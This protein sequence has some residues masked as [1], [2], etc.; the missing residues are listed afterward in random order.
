MK[1]NVESQEAI[2]VPD[3]PL[4]PD[5]N[6]QHQFQRKRTIYRVYQVIWYI[7]GVI[8]VLLVFRIVLKLLGANPLSGFANFIYSLSA[9]FAVPF[10]GVLPASAVG[11][12]VIEWS[13]FLA[14][15]VYLVLA[16][17]LVKL[18]QFFKPADPAD[19]ERAVDTEV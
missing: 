2:E 10:V 4:P 5:Y 8:E 16:Y 1:Y 18:F 17:G 12:S 3:D 7:L 19:V 9:P 13:T 6:P 14:M 15:I 11:T